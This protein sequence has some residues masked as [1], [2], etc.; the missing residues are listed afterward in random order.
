MADAAIL[1]PQSTEPPPFSEPSES[2]VG[3]PKGSGKRREA[4]A[5]A[6]ERQSFMEYTS[7]LTEAD[8]E[9]HLLYVYQWQPFIDL[10]RGG[11][12]KKYRKIYTCHMNEEAIK[13]DLGSGK[14]ELKLNRADEKGHEKTIKRLVFSIVDYDFPPNYPPGQWLDD[15]KNIDW[16]WAKPLL[17]K[18]YKPAAAAAS[19][20]GSPTWAEMMQFLEAQR[21]KDG[22]T[23]DQVMSTIVQILPQLLK[24]QSESQDPGKVFTAL[25]EAKEFMTPPAAPEDKTSALLLPLLIKLIDRDNKPASAP[26]QDPMIGLLMNQLAEL[27]KQNTKYLELILQ[28][29]SEAT[30]PLDQIDKFSEI[31]GKVSAIAAPAAPGSVWENLASDAIPKALGIV[32]TFIQANA[33]AKAAQARMQ[34]TMPARPGT[35]APTVVSMPPPQAAGVPAAQPT[36]NGVDNPAQPEIDMNDRTMLSTIAA[37]AAQAMNLEVPG[38]EFAEKICRRFGDVQYEAF[39]GRFPKSEILAKLR[40]VPEAWEMLSP[41]EP[42]LE[43]FI[44]DFYAFAEEPPPDDE[45]ETVPAKPANKKPKVKGK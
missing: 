36:T 4:E 26:A 6:D 16:I 27:Q 42:A 2:R 11:Q 15:P 37:F 14:Y 10:T 12:D 40:S 35:T 22:G 45:P 41:H 32:E 9:N 29:K 18:K 13:R 43:Q 21:P 5:T 38:D 7:S 25:K 33:A 3:R 24:Q 8:W 44:A 34:A 30:N 39:I 20:N 28:A 17:E 23:K 31:I 19:G 1:E